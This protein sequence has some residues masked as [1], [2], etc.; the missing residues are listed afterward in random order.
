[1]HRGEVLLRDATVFVRRRFRIVTICST[2][3]AVGVPTQV[4]ARKKKGRLHADP[5]YTSLA[6]GRQ[7]QP[8][9][10]Q[11]AVTVTVAVPEVAPL[12]ACTVFEKVPVAVPAVNRPVLLIVPP[13]A[14]TAHVGVM[15]TIL[16]YASL[17]VA[18]NCL[19]VRAG[20]LA[21]FGVT[22]I[23]ASGPAFTTTV[24]VPDTPP[25]LA[26]TVLV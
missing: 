20:T 26:L 22:V 25:L 2:V 23:L 10:G 11:L 3:P 15:P 19:F 1:M 7:R 5:L 9:S 17:P 4:R 6:A 18:V 12:D 21:G 14:T 16:P 8:R 13:P 24:A